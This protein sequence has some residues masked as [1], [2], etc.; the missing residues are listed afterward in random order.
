MES[1]GVLTEELK[2]KYKMKRKV[3][4]AQNGEVIVC[5][6]PNAEILT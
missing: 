1:A 5:V 6:L 4:N 2:V 3:M